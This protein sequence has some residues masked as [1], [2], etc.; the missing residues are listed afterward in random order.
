VNIS[1]KREE[2]LKDKINESE[3]VS[4]GSET[5]IAA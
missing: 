5:C 4:I 1:G 2:Y 3:S